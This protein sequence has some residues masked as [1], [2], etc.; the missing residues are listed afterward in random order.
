MW[1]QEIYAWIV[2]SVVFGWISTFL[3]VKLIK[4]QWH[5]TPLTLFSIAVTFGHVYLASSTYYTEEGIEWMYQEPILTQLP[6]FSILVFGNIIELQFIYVKFI[7]TALKNHRRWGSLHPVMM[8]EDSNSEDSNLEKSKIIPIT[9]DELTNIP[10]T[11]PPAP[12]PPFVSSISA[13]VLWVNVPTIVLYAIVVIVFLSCKGVLKEGQTSDLISAICITIMAVLALLNFIGIVSVTLH[14]LKQVER[15]IR[16]NKQDAH[17]LTLVSFLFMVFMTAT[18][19]IAW[20]AV[21]EPST[22]KPWSQSNPAWSTPD[23]AR[24]IAFKSMTVYLPLALLLLFC[25]VKSTSDISLLK[26]TEQ[27]A[28]A[29]AKT[30]HSTAAPMN[31]LHSEERMNK[32]LM[33]V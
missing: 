9:S 10:L 31:R 19:V 23:I 20:M 24:W 6:I 30:I 12:S 2:Y 27:A 14:C 8:E 3:I 17:V 32:R 33:L 16:Q 15:I 21:L 13:M 26:E 4:R 18:A 1:T 28:Q 29:E 25:L 11:T 22:L 5:L 7:V